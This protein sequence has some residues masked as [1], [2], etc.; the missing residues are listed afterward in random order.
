MST[1]DVPA[2]LVIPSA[3]VFRRLD[4]DARGG[5][6]VAVAEEEEEEDEDG[7][8]TLMLVDSDSDSAEE[9]RGRLFRPPPLDVAALLA[10]PL[11]IGVA[12]ELCVPEKRNFSRAAAS[13]EEELVVVP[14]RGILEEIWNDEITLLW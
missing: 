12:V 9:G 3:L 8:L 11:S 1:N 10:S 7:A 13:D 14:D 4:A 2:L 5:V 6:I